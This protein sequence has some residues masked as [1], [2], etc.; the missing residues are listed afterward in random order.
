LSIP[1]VCN[2]G[3][4]NDGSGCVPIS[5]VQIPIC[6]AGYHSDGFGNCLPP[7]VTCAEGYVSD[8]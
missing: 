4:E 2:S 6:P 3:F 1:I 7:I 8:G 5:I